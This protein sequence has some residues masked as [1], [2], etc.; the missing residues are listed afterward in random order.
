MVSD[1]SDISSTSDNF[2]RE[3][4]KKTKE[5]L[6]EV[7]IISIV[8]L[9]YL[10]ARATGILGNEQLI[11]VGMMLI[12]ILVSVA[13]I[14]QTWSGRR[15]GTG[16][17]QY[18]A[19]IYAVMIMGIVMRIGYMLSTNCTVRGHDLWEIDPSGAGHAGYLLQLL[20]KHQLPDTNTLQFYQQPLFYILGAVTSWFLNLFF[21]DMTYYNLVDAAK[22]VSCI[23]SCLS[24]VLC[25]RIAQ[26]SGLKD[27]G[28]LCTL[29]LT[30]FL[31]AFYLTGGTVNPDALAA[32]MMLY[33]YL[34][35]LRWLRNQSWKNTI[36]LAVI[37]GL[38]MMTKISCGVVALV[39]A[40]I[41]LWQF[42][43]ALHKK[44]AGKLLSKYLVFGC[45]SIPL[46]MWYS[47]RN[48]IL[49]NQSLTYV[50]WQGEQSD[51]Y[52]G[53][54]PIIQRIL[55]IDVDN[56]LQGPYT[57]VRSDYNLP[58]YY[59]KSALFGE[60]SFDVPGFIPVLLL[61]TAFVLSLFCISA[62]IGSIRKRRIRRDYRIM[63]AVILSLVVYGS[64]VLFYLKYPFGCSMDFRYITFLAVPLSILLGKYAETHKVKSFYL[65]LLLSIYAVF[66]ALMY[67]Y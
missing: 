40:G 44:K 65:H 53:S 16:Q 38:A 50:L 33:A 46:G 42:I 13:L 62:V 56:L 51:L 22:T 67:S 47:I 15:F 7:Y 12:L 5:W 35:T 57:D 4:N 61:F 60:F 10:L 63:I 14:W 34:F 59:L 32:L 2:K 6:E 48:Y 19:G 45:I 28:I 8:L 52:T 30:A 36:L 49:F 66:S 24:L 31:P 21:D 3:K 11:H 17:S 39:T 54:H 43:I 25:R 41:F 58:V 9:S 23:A 1:V 37:F 20:T 64:G 27:Q 55:L 18:N 29:M 26:E